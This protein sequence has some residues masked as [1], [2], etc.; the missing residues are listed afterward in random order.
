[1]L[2]TLG[3][4]LLATGL[5]F[6]ERT[7]RLNREGHV[8][9]RYSKAIEQLGNDSVDVRI[10]GVYALERIARDSRI[11]Y[12]TITEV[13]CAFV[14]EHTSQPSNRGRSPLAA[15]SSA[16]VQAAATVLARRHAEGENIDLSHSGLNN[17]RMSG[18]WHRAQFNYCHIA[19]T[20]FT[21]SVMDGV[22]FSFCEIKV[23][24]FNHISAKGAHFVRGKVQA[25]FVDAD[26]RDSDFYACDLTGSDFS[27]RFDEDDED[28]PMV[29]S[30]AQLAGARFTL[31]NLTDVNLKGVDLSDARGLTQTQ[32]GQ[33]VIDADTI[34]PRVFAEEASPAVDADDHA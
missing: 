4:L 9:D 24:G 2:Q 34:P 3:A 15:P 8:T 23:C 16:D 14:R 28:R 25:W 11:D 26:L 32:L 30:P 7:F 10:G 13:L 31:A 33:A 27:G 5:V 1:L 22:S 17:L 29:S 12:G 21:R 20:V 19:D 6:T 18:Q